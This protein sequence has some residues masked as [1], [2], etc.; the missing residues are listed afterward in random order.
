VFQCAQ[1]SALSTFR[2][3]LSAFCFLLSAL[4]VALPQTVSSS[5][6]LAL[7]FCHLCNSPL[8]AHFGLTFAP[9]KLDTNCHWAQNCHKIL[10]LTRKGRLTN[11]QAPLTSA[12]RPSGAKTIR[13]SPQEAMEFSLSGF[14]RENSSVSLAEPILSSLAL[15]GGSFRFALGAPLGRE[16]R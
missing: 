16:E 9:P 8:F 14:F 13:D 2:F 6:R 1:S 3:L 4:C 15:F 7:H 12:R 10:Q 11:Q 5:L